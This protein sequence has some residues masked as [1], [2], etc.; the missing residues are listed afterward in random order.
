MLENF[1]VYECATYLN[2][3]YGMARQCSKRLA[4]NVSN[5]I[6]DNCI[7]AIVSPII[8]LITPMGVSWS[9]L[10]ALF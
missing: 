3:T 5:Y 1:P 7:W 4:A 9:F 10:S 6:F 2:D 8:A